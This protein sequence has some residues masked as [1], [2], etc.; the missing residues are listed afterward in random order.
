[1]I[2]FASQRLLAARGEAELER[3]ALFGGAYG[4]WYGLVAGY[5]FFG[6]PDWMLAYLQSGAQL[7]KPVAYLFFLLVVVA[8]GV[9]GAVAVGWLLH[10]GHKNLSWSVTVAGL[11][12]LLAVLRVSWRQYG[13]VGTFED[14]WQGHAPDAADVPAFQTAKTVTVV[15]AGIPFAALVAWRL[16]IGRK[17]PQPAAKS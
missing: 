14:F 16:W 4:L 10:R 11:L 12:G 2:A 3:V 8:A 7:F 15:L 9:S 5:L 17:T 6:Y 13:S 1:M